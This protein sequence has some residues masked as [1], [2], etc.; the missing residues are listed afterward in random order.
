MR[1]KKKLGARNNQHYLLNVPI[2]RHLKNIT[3]IWEYR[4]FILS[5]VKRELQSKY[6]NSLLGAAWTFINPLCMILVYTFVF[7]KVMQAKLPGAS[8]Y[9]P[10]HYSIYLCSG[11]FTWGLFAEIITRSVSIFMDN[12]TLLKKVAFPRICLPVII[13]LS[14]T[15]N[16]FIVLAIFTIFILII[17]NFPGLAYVGILPLLLILISFASGLGITLG[18]LNVFFRDIGQFTSILLQFWFWLTPIVYSAD[19]LPSSAKLVVT[20]NPIAPLIAGFQDIFVARVPPNPYTL[21]YPVVVSSLLCL[22]ALIL[23]RTHS[24][25]IVDEL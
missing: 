10:F 11:I 25:D 8:D 3:S 20:L 13:T 9:S 4:D 22:T 1:N 2:K 14:S 21:I 5:T 17:G 24:A 12:S 23:F 15:L 6:R 16:F 7:S 18:V 19:I